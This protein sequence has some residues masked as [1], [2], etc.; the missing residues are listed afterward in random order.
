[1]LRWLA[2]IAVMSHAGVAWLHGAAHKQL[3][4]GLNTWQTLFVQVV[5]TAAPLV[6]MVLV[7]TRLARW[8]YLLL[9]LVMAGALGFG[10]YHHY[11]AVSPDHVAHLP[12]GDA[13]TMFKA[14]AVL[15]IVTE[16][17]A[18][19]IGFWGWR[20]GRAKS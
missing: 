20:A 19:G 1:M 12:P 10:I 6:A 8:S 5:I 13:Q 4:V 15:L 3:G 14:T 2:T 16:T 11:I 18:L 9:A 7:W 17:I